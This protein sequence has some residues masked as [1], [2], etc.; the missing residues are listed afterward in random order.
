MAIDH[1]V[2][3][4]GDDEGG[5]AD[6][7]TFAISVLLSGA[8]ALFLFGWLA[9]RT[10]AKGGSRVASVGL[11]CSVL[12]VVPGIALLW[13]GLPF[14]S[15]GAGIAL[16]ME[17]RREAHWRGVGAVALGR[18]VVVLGLALYIYALTTR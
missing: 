4:E 3:T 5:L 1:L 15:A 6:P 10:L 2:G 11:V 16:G 9:P 12:S 14:V 13:L 18:A 8:L 7:T 17:G